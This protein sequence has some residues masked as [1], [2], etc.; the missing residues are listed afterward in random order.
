M[1]RSRSDCFLAI[2]PG[3]I[4]FSKTMPYP[5]SAG[6]RLST[7]TIF[8]DWYNWNDLQLHVFNIY[9]SPYSFNSILSGTCN[10]IST[11]WSNKSSRSWLFLSEGYPG[12]PI[13]YLVKPCN[14]RVFLVQQWNIPFKQYAVKLLYRGHFWAVQNGVFIKEKMGVEMKERVLVGRVRF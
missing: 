14:H 7:L 10:H 1:G 6:Q 4:L 12:F 11:K 2:R 13:L 9:I 8:K 5:G 3:S